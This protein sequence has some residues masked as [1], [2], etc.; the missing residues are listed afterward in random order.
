MPT[1]GV[2]ELV[3]FILKTGDLISVGIGTSRQKT[4]LLGTH[5]HQRIQKK[6]STATEKEVSLKYPILL[7]NRNFTIQGRADGLHK[8]NNIYDEIR[9]IK[10]SSLAFSELTSNTLTLYWAQAKIY[11]H[12]LMT[13]K[14]LSS[15]SLKLIYVQTTT[16]ETTEKE[17]LITKEQAAT[18]FD[19]VISEY[20]KWITL[21]EKLHT[22]QTTSIK[23]LS[24]PFKSYRRNQHEL[25]VNVYKAILLKKRLFV[26]APTGT[27]K[28]ISTLFPTIKALGQDKIARI[29][30]LT[31]KQ[32]TRK[33]A[34]DALHLMSQKKLVLRSIT[35]TAKEQITFPEEIDIPDEENPY[36]LGYYDRIRPALKDILEHETQITKEIVCNYARKHTVDP[37][38]FSLDISLFCA[39]IICDYNY[40]FDPLVYLQR[41]FTEEDS[42]NCFLIDEAHNLVERSRSMYTKEIDSQT[43]SSLELTLNKKKTHYQSLLKHLK[44]ISDCLNDIKQPLIDYQ[45]KYVIFS[46]QLSNL[47]KY[48]HKFCDYTQ[49][50]MRSHTQD[51]NIKEILD[52]FFIC[53]SYLK[54]SDFYDE[55]F[56][57]KV[58]LL[59]NNQIKVKIFC[60]NPSSFIDKSLKLAGSAILFSATLSPLS[61]YQE[62]LG[63]LTKSVGYQLDSPFSQK[64]L[65]LFITANVQ[66]TYH[67]RTQSLQDVLASIYTMISAKTGNYLI[68]MPSYSYL[69]QIVEGFNKAY[70]LTNILVQSSSMDAIQRDSFLKEFKSNNTQTLVGFAVLGG[71]FSEGIDLKGNRLS[72]VAV[73]SVGLPGISPEN[74]ALKDYFNAQSKNGFEYAYKL[75]GLNNIFQAAGRVIRSTTDCGVVLLI[76]SR[77]ATLNYQKYY[78]PHWS[79]G[80]ILYNQEQLKESLA[81]FWKTTKTQKKD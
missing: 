7:A 21:K 52:F 81:I 36:L 34:E 54:I 14:N 58:D 18:F 62:I 12:I 61:Y 9:E 41:F 59:P 57:T 68:F 2:R 77:F 29:F 64:K 45:Q 67:K 26:E 15:L 11:S 51:P 66:T 80:I 32:S 5:I 31:A 73:V 56:R 33:V 22:E 75:P 78:P 69:E 44:N 3:E 49:E 20:E 23:H 76:D 17:L 6:W 53:Y 65:G 16:M 79:H 71:I 46:E 74:D 24:F 40:L 8:T 1:I 37:F 10:T 4:A 35:L 70:P 30:Y 50:W 38:E 28:T 39:V 48:L 25:A 19:N 13:Q 63:G 42:N 43:L 72:G 47:N 27:G 55:T 60:L